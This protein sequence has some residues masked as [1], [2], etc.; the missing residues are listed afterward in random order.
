MFSYFLYSLLCILGLSTFPSSSILSSKYVS[1]S[2]ISQKQT[3]RQMS[4]SKVIL[5][6]RIIHQTPLCL[7]DENSAKE[8]VQ[9]T[10]ITV[11]KN[12]GLHF[13][14]S[15][16]LLVLSAST[17]SKV[18]WHLSSK[19]IFLTV[20]E[21]ESKIRMLHAGMLMKALCPDG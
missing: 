5:K 10:E 8:S 14:K 6:S 11:N 16:A 13:S 17:A 7:H 1:W 2:E 3:E 20:L 15:D 9:D 21:G 4:V 12:G 19:K 18:E